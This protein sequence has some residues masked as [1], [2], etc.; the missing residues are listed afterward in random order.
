MRKLKIF[1][2]FL[3]IVILTALLA[4]PIASALPAPDIEADAMIL[5]E[6]K[7]G[8]ILWERN[9]DIR[10]APGSIAKV[11][12]VLL[13]VLEV[14]D[15]QAGLDDS[16]TASESFLS[17]LDENAVTQNIKPG[18]T[19]SY[20]DLL[21]C[22]YLT[23]ANDACNILAEEVS[24]SIRGFVRKMNEKAKELGC[25]NTYFMNPGGLAD[26]GQ[27]TSAWDQYLIFK[28]AVGHPLFL[29]IAG[30][31]SY[32]SKSDAD[33]PERILVN[34]NLM[35]QQESGHHYKYCI[36][37]KTASSSEYGSSFVAYADNGE[38]SLISVVFG[39]KSAEGDR[40]SNASKCFSETQR[41]LE[42]GMSNFAWRDIVNEK[43]IAAYE[44]IALAKG[45]ETIGLRP[46]APITVLTRKDLTAQ[47]IE[48]DIIIYGKAEGKVLSAPVKKG[49]ILGEIR[50]SIDGTAC[51]Q[52]HLVAAHDAEL[53]KSAFIRSEVTDT[54]SLFWVQLV[55]FLVVAFIVYYIWLVI[56]DFR[57]RYEKKRRAEENRRKMME[58]RQ[59][60]T[61]KK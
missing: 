20:R 30:K 22:A 45:M 46:A 59:K 23:S 58:Y 16:V 44:D 37:G 27:Y 14:E 1:T 7:S 53:D 33:S 61:I 18:E 36:A 55:I 24:G 29:E 39:V 17:G 28:E 50:V 40:E 43:E 51:G 32:V 8:N 3:I 11:M 9:K 2:V 31:E 26:P 19:I 48:K 4:S 54:L 35:L 25:R 6:I 21:Y 5:A 52:A 56:R 38:L 57:R 41:L 12:T 13:A 60:Q 15:G 42:W 47:D 49:E 10:V 34:P